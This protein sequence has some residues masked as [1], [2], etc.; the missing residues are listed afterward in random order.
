MKTCPHCGNK[1]N[2]QEFSPYC[3]M[4]CVIKHRR[5]YDKMCDELE[6]IEMEK[7]RDKFKWKL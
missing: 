7:Q 1:H 2:Y 3:D 5:E 6:E 4:D